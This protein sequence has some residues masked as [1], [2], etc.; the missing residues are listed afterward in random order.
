MVSTSENMELVACS[1]VENSN[2]SS[3]QLSREL[4]I[5]D[6]SLR[7]M[8][9]RM[10]YRV[11][12]PRLIHA[13]HV[14]DY[15]R[16]LEFCEWFL[17]CFDEDPQFYRHILWSDEATFKLN[18]T[19]NRHN[20]VY[21]CTDNPHVTIEEELNLPGVCGRAFMLTDCLVCTFSTILLRNQVTWKC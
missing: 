17:N 12:Q 7:R 18:G 16:R 19:V 14:D 3:R 4:E 20:C 21:W 9:K 1:F 11:Y 6:T 8:L 13:L 2:Q 5:A 10:G 15:D